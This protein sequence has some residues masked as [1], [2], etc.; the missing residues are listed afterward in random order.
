M[1]A[2][3]I[4]LRE[5]PPKVQDYLRKRAIE[6]CRPMEDIISDYIAET[7]ELINKAKK[8]GE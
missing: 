2:V 8:G 1:N 6:E 5:F 3:T 7:S 4:E